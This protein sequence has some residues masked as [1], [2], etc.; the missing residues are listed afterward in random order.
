MPK[1]VQA[2][3]A[4][5]H[6]KAFRRIAVELGDVEHPAPFY[7]LFPSCGNRHRSPTGN[8]CQRLKVLQQRKYTLIY[9][10]H[11]DNTMLLR[12]RQFIS[13]FCIL[14]KQAS[15]CFSLCYFKLFI[16]AGKEE[17]A[18]PDSA[19]EGRQDGASPHPAPP[20]GSPLPHRQGNE[21]TR[22]LEV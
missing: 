14:P 8:K 15:I 4:V 3:E 11:Q 22:T 16:T 5:F 21:E 1:I 13:H 19:A 7:R 9:Y 17:G 12:H 10:Y 18:P 20:P 2:N 6:S